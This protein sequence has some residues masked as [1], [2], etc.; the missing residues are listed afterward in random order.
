M[1]AIAL[2]SNLFLFSTNSRVGAARTARTQL[3]TFILPANQLFKFLA[4]S[5]PLENILSGWF[6][7]QAGCNADTLLNGISETTHLVFE[8]VI[9]FDV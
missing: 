2:V 7:A 9:R 1:K 5:W 4:D 8:I 6:A 3:P